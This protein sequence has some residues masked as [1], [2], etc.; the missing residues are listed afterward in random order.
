MLMCD[1]VSHVSACDAHRGGKR[2]TRSRVD[3]RPSCGV[4]LRYKGQR[5][6]QVNRASDILQLAVGKPHLPC[7]HF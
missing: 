1:V 2:S 3:T 4:T 5:P 7:R 6:W